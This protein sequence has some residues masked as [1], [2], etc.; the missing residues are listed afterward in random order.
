MTGIINLL[1]PPGMSS[2]SAV[3][4]VKRILGEKKAGHTGTLDP[5]A[6]GV[7]PVCL[8]RA[9]KLADYLAE[10]EKEY[11]AELTLGAATDTLDSYGHVQRTMPVRLVEPLQLSE[12]MAGFRGRITQVPPAYSAVKVNGKPLYS[13][14]RAGTEVQVKPRE[15]E[16][17]KLELLSGSGTGPFMFRIVCSRGTYVRSLLA[18]IAEGLGQIGY[19]SLI[20]RSRVGKFELRNAVTLTELE[21]DT[22]HNLVIDAEQAAPGEKLVLPPYLFRF[23]KDGI[24]IRPDKVPGLTLMPGKLYSI[25]CRGEYF[26][27]GKLM[28]RYL[29]LR[30]RVWEP[31][32]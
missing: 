28:D 20:L 8:G 19:T 15:I 23:L 4:A 26:G 27:I 11:I 9:T 24:R 6:A 16:I 14:A 17:A 18:G 30:A 25:S 32:A 3:T 7:L 29:V 5:G 10:G 22:E 31:H 1:K 2:Q 21:H 13:Y 12:V